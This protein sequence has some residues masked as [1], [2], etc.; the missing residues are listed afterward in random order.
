MSD[1]LNKQVGGEHYKK[2][3]IQHVEFVHANNIPYIEANAMKYIMRHR[4][5]NG[6]QDLEKAIHYIEIL[7][8]ME[9]LKPEID[10]AVAKEDPSVSP[11]LVKAIDCTRIGED[12]IY[13]LEVWQAGHPIV[14]VARASRRVL[15]GL[16]LSKKREIL[17]FDQLEAIFSWA[18]Q[19]L[20]S[21][22][23]QVS[24]DY[25]LE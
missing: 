24:I 8:E 11:C 3:K 10:V 4:A 16:K 15:T 17:K 7:L 2:D 25:T 20:F 1:A 13:N 14:V 18:R 6:R 21:I 9:Y 5:K 19:N 22:H 23:E 12:L